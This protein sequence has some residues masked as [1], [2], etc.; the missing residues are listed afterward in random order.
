MSTGVSLSIATTTPALTPY[1]PCMS[2]ALP[3]MPPNYRRLCILMLFSALETVFWNICPMSWV[4]YEIQPFPQFPPKTKHNKWKTYKVLVKVNDFANYLEGRV[5]EKSLIKK[6]KPT[7]FP[8]IR[9]NSEYAR[10]GYF[11]SKLGVTRSG[12]RRRKSQPPSPRI[13]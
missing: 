6:E 5:S 12:W 1:P 4:T 8:E 11:P 13:R 7:D 2:K 3:K 10:R 9:E